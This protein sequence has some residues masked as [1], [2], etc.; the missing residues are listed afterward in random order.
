MGN[1]DSGTMLKERVA[2]LVSPEQ[3]KILQGRAK[4]KNTSVGEYLRLLAFPEEGQ[5]DFAEL[6]KEV[7]DVKRRVLIL[8]AQ[9]IKEK[10]HA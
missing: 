4:A 2:V 5:T 7:I 1:D 10:D 9:F 3:K 8:E 6:Q